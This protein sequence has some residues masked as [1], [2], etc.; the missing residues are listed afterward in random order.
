MNILVCC[1]IVYEE[2]DISVLPDRGLSYDR[3]EL[4]LSLYD[5]NAVEQAVQ[6][7]GN[8]RALSIGGKNKDNGKIKKNLLSRG[9]QELYI[10]TDEALSG[11]DTH[12]TATVLAAAA[13]KIGFDL[14]LC[15]EGS[16]DLYA[17]QTGIQLGELLGVPVISSVSK[18]TAADG[19][20]IAERTA[21]DSVDVIEAP[22]PAVVCLT[23]DINEPRIPGMKDILAA[24]KKPVTE[25][26]LADLGIAAP[27]VT[28]DVISILAPVGKDRKRIIVEG[29][30][31]ATELFDNIKNEVRS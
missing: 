6:L 11:A 16:A 27:E 18:L 12:Q 14:I 7:S 10:V 24:G 19:K 28:V 3:A 17:Q 26:S 13:K 31:K 25:W 15:G 2:Q 30:D 20:I 5:L 9:P 23:S 4:K 8:I 21:D 22:L 29:D 1:K